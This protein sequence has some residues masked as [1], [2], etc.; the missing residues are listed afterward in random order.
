[1]FDLTAREKIYLVSMLKELLTLEMSPFLDSA[2]TTKYDLL[3]DTLRSC[4]PEGMR[5]IIFVQQ[6]ATAAVLMQMLARDPLIPDDF[7]IGSFVGESSYSKRK[8]M[9]YELVNP[10]EQQQSLGDFRSG[11]KNLLTTTNVLEEGIDVPECNVV[12]CFE[13]PANLKSFIQK[14][15][16]AKKQGSKLVLMMPEN[17]ETGLADPAEKWQELEKQMEAVYSDELRP[18]QDAEIDEA[19]EEG[20]DDFKYRVEHTG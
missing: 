2:I 7:C 15:G 3:R 19:H 17:P 1:M 12:I 6:R 20:S 18:V 13:K 14:R 5:G 4:T 8:A 16:R 11:S 10:K 9:I